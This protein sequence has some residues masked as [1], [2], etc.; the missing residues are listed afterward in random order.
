MRRDFSFSSLGAR[1]LGLRCGFSPTSACGPLTGVC[2]LGC[3]GAHESAPVRK[4]RGVDGSWG[5]RS[6]CHYGDRT[7]RRGQQMLVLW[8]CPFWQ[9][10]YQM[11]TEAG[12]SAQG[13]RLQWRPCPLCI[14]P[15]WHLATMVFRVSSTDIL[16]CR[17]P[18]SH[19]LRLSPCSQQQSSP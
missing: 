6:T 12:A 19:P 8:E 14:T 11:P 4:G 2:S 16:S 10:P 9:E 15:Q 13:E 17:F 18:H 1:P 7:R 3:P 5:H